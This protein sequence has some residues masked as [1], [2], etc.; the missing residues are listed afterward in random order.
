VSKVNSSFG[1]SIKVAFGVA[2]LVMGVNAIAADADMSDAAIAERIKP[3]GQLNTG[4]PFTP[5]APAASAPAESAAAETAPAEAAS[6]AP[7]QVAAAP[8]AG[9]RSGEAVYKSACFVCHDMGIAGA[10]KLGDTAAWAPRIAQGMA[11]LQQH[12]IDGFQGSTGVMPARGTCAACS[13]DELKAA[14]EFMVESSK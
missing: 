10:P 14:V 5:A 12:A 8:A 7:A 9:P 3:V 4:A 13:D 1:F 2:A 11:T 6:A